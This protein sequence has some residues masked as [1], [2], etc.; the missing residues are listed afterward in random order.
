MKRFI[1]IIVASLA[2]GSAAAQDRVAIE[3]TEVATPSDANVLYHRIRNAAQAVCPAVQ[4]L[5]LYGQFVAR[6]CVQ[7]AVAAAVADVDNPLLTA[8]HHGATGDKL[9]SSR[10]TSR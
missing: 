4:V 6:K 8:R 9:Y 3:Y 10:A 5:G 1:A 2:I 7:N